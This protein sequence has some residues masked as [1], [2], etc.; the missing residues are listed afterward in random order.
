MIYFGLLHLLLPII[1]YIWVQH[2]RGAN[3]KYLQVFGLLGLPIDVL[4]NYTTLSL[5]FWDFPKVTEYTFSKR[6]P[7]LCS[8]NGWRGK[9]AIK[10][11]ELLNKVD[12]LHNHI[13]DK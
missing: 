7:R 12:P 5:L 4:L 1:Y 2:K 6:L 3:Y 8:L 13:K 11:K 10:V 9:F